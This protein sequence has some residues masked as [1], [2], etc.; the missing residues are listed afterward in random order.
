MD[1]V[2]E[3]VPWERGLAPEGLWGVQ[4][5]RKTLDWAVGRR[6][7]P[8]KMPLECMWI[9]NHPNSGSFSAYCSIW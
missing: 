7:Q 1:C 5:L 6:V 8:R 2:L 3:S 9:K 4:W